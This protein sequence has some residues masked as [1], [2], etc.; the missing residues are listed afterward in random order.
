MTRNLD[1]WNLKDLKNVENEQITAISALRFTNSPNSARV[2]CEGAD[3]DA[4]FVVLLLAC[5][6]AAFSLVDC[7]YSATLIGRDFERGKNKRGKQETWIYFTP[8]QFYLFLPS[9]H[10]FLQANG[11]KIY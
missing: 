11:R 6:N 2:S 8:I 1:F 4:I 5:Q 9:S 3:L 10:K 7:G